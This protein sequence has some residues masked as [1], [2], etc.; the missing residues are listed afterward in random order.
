[1]VFCETN[2]P[3]PLRAVISDKYKLIYNLKANVYEL[4]NLKDDPW[5]HKNLWGSDVEGGKKMKE[6]LDEWLDRV[7]YSREQGVQSQEV[8]KEALLAERPAPKQPADVTAATVHV[9]GYDLGKPGYKPGDTVDVTFYFEATAETAS[10]FRLE[11]GA[12]SG[13]AGASP[14]TIRQDKVP[15]DG[16]FPTS[17]WKKG[18]FVKETYA[19]RLPTSWAPGPI[20]I[21]FRLLDDHRQPVTILG[22]GGVTI[23]PE[24]TLGDLAL[25]TPPS[26]EPEP[27]KTAPAMPPHK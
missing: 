3:D 18:E 15:L 7:Y 8:R 22:P 19:L 20:H 4:Y 2:Y 17:R 24:A 1:V 23:G 21:T 9:L 16:L 27:A 13:V 12:T 11:A 5:E 26:P 14:P 10:N 25:E 6:L